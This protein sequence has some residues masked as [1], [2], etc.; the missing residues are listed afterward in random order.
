MITA[1][2]LSFHLVFNV[3]EGGGAKPNNSK[4]SYGFYIFSCSIVLYLLGLQHSVF[5]AQ[6]V[7][8]DR[9]KPSAV[10]YLG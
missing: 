1:F 5:L 8:K 9:Q 6:N 4:I 3:G 10:F 2:Y 7:Q